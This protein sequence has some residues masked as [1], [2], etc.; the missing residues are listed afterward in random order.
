MCL[1]A[2]AWHRHPD[3]PLILAA[4]R[5]E[6]RDRPTAAADW[7]PD[8]PEILGGR[9]LR[10]GG[11]WLGI[12]SPGRLAALTNFRDGREPPPNAVSRGDLVADYL[13]SGIT[14]P[15]FAR[16][17]EGS[18][19]RY[20][21]FSLIF[22]DRDTLYYFSNRGGPRGPVEP[23][24]HT[25]SNHLLD[26]PWP[27]SERLRQEFLA[28]FTRPDP[29]DLFAMLDDT[30]P[31]ADGELPETGVGYRL[32]KRLSAPCVVGETYGTRCSTVILLDR[33]N[34]VI[35]EEA[36]RDSHGRRSPPRHFEFD[37]V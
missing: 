3:Y 5:D 7:W 9:D 4:N 27:K 21:G 25:L 18:A 14:P 1:L 19:D 10:A 29:A 31:A 11:S 26:T 35:F 15:G 32:E 22:G 20:A 17:L 28:H 30:T 24:V 36:Q 37:L 34:H 6:M 16:A 13:Q 8:A 23:G 33:R 12:T 2:F